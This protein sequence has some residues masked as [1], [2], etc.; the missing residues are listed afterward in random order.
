M[1]LNDFLALAQQYL[2]A[3]AD[4]RGRRPGVACGQ[5]AAAAL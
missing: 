4:L 2:P 3:R 1:C 5:Q